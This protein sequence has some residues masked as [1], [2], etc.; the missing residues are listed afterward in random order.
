MD[1]F[2]L[3]WKAKEF[4][5]STRFIELA[6]EVNEA[7]PYHVVEAVSSALNQRSKPLKGSRILVLGLAYKRDVDDL[8]ESPALVHNRDAAAG[9]RRG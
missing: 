7:M 1:P 6:G 3:S 4:D 5:F 9:G 8:R 2:Y